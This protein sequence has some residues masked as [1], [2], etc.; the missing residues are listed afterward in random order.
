MAYQMEI[1]NNQEQLG[2]R[3][4]DQGHATKGFVSLLTTL[5]ITKPFNSVSHSNEWLKNLRV[6]SLHIFIIQ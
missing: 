3:R 5:Y 1:E 4:E 6:D 2:E